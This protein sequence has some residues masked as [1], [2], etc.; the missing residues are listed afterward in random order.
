MYY[1]C[2]TQNIAEN[3]TNN[4]THTVHEAWGTRISHYTTVPIHSRHISNDRRL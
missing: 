4:V 2:L 3:Q 1:V